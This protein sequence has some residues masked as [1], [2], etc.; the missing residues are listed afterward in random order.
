[1]GNEKVHIVQIA[2]IAKLSN[3][4]FH[5]VLMNEDKHMEA[6]SLIQSWSKKDGSIQ[7][8]DEVL[9]VEEEDV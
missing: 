6:V 4:Q 5:E 9:G 3:G 7:L 8:S 2:I 1:M